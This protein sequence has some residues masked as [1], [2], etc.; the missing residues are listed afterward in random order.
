MNANLQRLVARWSEAAELS[1]YLK[2]DVTREQLDALEAQIDGSGLAAGRQYVSKA[3]AA[4]RFRQDF[5]DLA[6]T[7]D[8]L[9][10]NPVSGLVRGPAEA[11][12][13][14]DRRAVDTLADESLDSAGVADVRYDRRCW[15]GSER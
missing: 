14:R 1:V 4:A 13:A 2:D 6:R 5:P 15:R 11:R 9:G 3:D 10:T 8:Q 7:A 12:V